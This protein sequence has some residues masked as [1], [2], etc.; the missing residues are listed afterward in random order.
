MVNSIYCIFIFFMLIQPKI[1]FGC[2]E[3]VF[4]LNPSK[5]TNQKYTFTQLKELSQQADNLHQGNQ[6]IK[7]AELDK[8]IAD[9]GLDPNFDIPT[10]HLIATH[11]YR[12]GESYHLGRGIKESLKQALKCFHKI[13]TIF[14]EKTEEIE[15]F[16]AATYYLSAICS[17]CDD[18]DIR[19]LSCDYIQK[20]AALPSFPKTPSND[21]KERIL[22]CLEEVSF[23]AWKQKDYSKADAYIEKFYKFAKDEKVH[24]PSY[25]FPL[26]IVHLPY[27]IKYQ[28]KREIS[29][30]C[31][32]ITTIQ[33]TE[34]FDYLAKKN[35]DLFNLT[36]EH[37]K[38]EQTKTPNKQEILGTLL[39]LEKSLDQK[40]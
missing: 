31:K 28:K 36:V 18:E 27:C 33:V 19:K 17:D 29:W 2:D 22:S 8:K 26:S 4:R 1:V 3:V 16:I 37:F 39:K 40:P 34:W 23:N 13:S 9:V 15:L 14:A 7:A 38:T 25:A 35:Q 32:N 11:T 24:M 10:N 6:F 5:L 21:T 20:I 12:L 30:L